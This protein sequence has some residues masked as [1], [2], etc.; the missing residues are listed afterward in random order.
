MRGLAV[1]RG[2][3]P[4]R[5]RTCDLRIRSPLLYPAELWAL[6]LYFPGYSRIDVASGG[7]HGP[8]S[9]PS[10]IKVPYQSLPSRAASCVFEQGRITDGKTQFYQV[11]EARKTVPRLPSHMVENRL[12]VEKDRE[13]SDTMKINRRTIC[14]GPKWKTAQEESERYQETMR[15][16]RDRNDRLLAGLPHLATD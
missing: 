11:M 2:S 13:G 10:V 4:S 12:L 1:T 7:C 16:Y 8:E 14:F 6:L 3:T 5:I 15:D 9:T